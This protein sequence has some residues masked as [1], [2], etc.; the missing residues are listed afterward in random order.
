MPRDDG[1]AADLY[2]LPAVGYYLLTGTPLFVATD[3][4]EY[5]RLHQTKQPEKVFDFLQ[6][7][8]GDFPGVPQERIRIFITGSGGNMV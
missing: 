6:R 4:R 3:V 5:I 2:S 1:S 7:I 8:V